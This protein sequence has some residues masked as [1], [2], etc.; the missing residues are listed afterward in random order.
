MCY[1]KDNIF[2]QFCVLPVGAN[3]V[4]ARGRSMISPTILRLRRLGGRRL[5]RAQHIFNENAVARGGIV[6]EDVCHRADELAVLND[7]AARHE[8]GQVGTTLFINSFV[9]LGIAS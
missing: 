5:R 4:F 9:S 6:D 3:T 2:I 8:C 7:W 1:N